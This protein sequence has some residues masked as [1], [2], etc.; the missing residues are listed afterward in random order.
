MSAVYAL[1][2]LVKV[3]TFVF[4]AAPVIVVIVLSFSGN[5][6]QLTFPPPSWGLTQY[7]SFFGSDYYISSVIR[8]FVVSLPAAA[9]AT[10]IG[11]PAVIAFE[12]SRLPGRSILQALS[13]APIILPGVAYAVALYGLYADLRLLGSYTGLIL[14][15]VML[16][17]PLVVLI[18][19]AGLRR[20]PAD[21]ELVAMS[22]GASRTRATIGITIRLLA[23]SIGAAALLAFVMAFDEAVLVNFVGMGRII[24]LPKAIF[25]SFRSGIEPLITAIAV[26]LMATTALVMLAAT[27]LRHRSVGAE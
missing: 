20:I 16:A 14:A 9:L 1:D 15:N 5:A 21:L 4:L 10:A 23:P 6:T 18:A 13:V 17:L 24:T 19:G 25:D 8:S 7:E 26:L 27:R 3:A 12:R 11:V 22:L 2:W